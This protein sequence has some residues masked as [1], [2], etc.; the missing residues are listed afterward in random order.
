MGTSPTRATGTIRSEVV[1]RI[2]GTTDD[3]VPPAGSSGPEGLKTLVKEDGMERMAIRGTI[4]F[5]VASC[6]LLVATAASP[7][8]AQLAG[9]PPPPEYQVTEGGDLIIGGD[10]QI[11]CDDLLLLAEE[12]AGQER[13]LAEYIEIC[14]E[15]GFPPQS[16]D[17]GASASPDASASP[18]APAAGGTLPET[19]GPAPV[20]LGLGAVAATCGLLLARRAAR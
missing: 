7:A 16:P 1:R 20:L 3:A 9:G 8:A 14:T 11:A 2:G 4:W 15:A 13:L 18:S 5:V 10:V 12:Q 19:G 17:S 6:A